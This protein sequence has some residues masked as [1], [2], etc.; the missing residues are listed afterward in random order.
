MVLCQS[1]K[2]GILA[3]DE[4]FGV[5]AQSTLA[6]DTAD[7]LMFSCDISI[8]VEAGLTTLALQKKQFRE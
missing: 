6:G 8:T 5:W 7:F 4:I 2:N 3:K 1:E